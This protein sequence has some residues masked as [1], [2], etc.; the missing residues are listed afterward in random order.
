MYLLW[1]GDPGLWESTG[2]LEGL[3]QVLRPRTEMQVGWAQTWSQILFTKVMVRMVKVVAK[4]PQVIG[5]M[6]AM[7]VVIVM[8]ILMI[9]VMMIIMTVVVMIMV[10]AAL[11]SFTWLWL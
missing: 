2:N 11:V 7:V 9:M 1:N 3:L 5:M 10:V 8:L 6:L 4:V